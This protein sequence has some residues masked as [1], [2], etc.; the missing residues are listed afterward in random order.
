MVREGHRHQADAGAGE[1]R[2]RSRAVPGAHDQTHSGQRKGNGEGLVGERGVEDDELR[3]DRVY[4]HGDPSGAGPTG[5]LFRHVAQQGHQNHPARQDDKRRCQHRRDTQLMD[6]RGDRF[7][8][9][10]ARADLKQRIGLEQLVGFPDVAQRS[11]V[12]LFVET[13]EEHR[14]GRA[15]HQCGGDPQAD[16]RGVTQGAVQIHHRQHEE[17]AAVGD[18]KAEVRKGLGDGMPTLPRKQHGAHLAGE[19]RQLP[20]DQDGDAPAP[21]RKR[22]G[23]QLATLRAKTRGATRPLDHVGPHYRTTS[24]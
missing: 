11:H 12:Q 22:P 24:P 10:I 3:G 7:Q 23:Q 13:R 6:Q 20:Y 21:A 8:T 2:H 9:W 17:R 16:H 14:I 5:Q 4:R 19:R 1:E 15:P 18:D